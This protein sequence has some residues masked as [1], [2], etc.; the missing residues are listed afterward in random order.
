M[1]DY[2]T[3]REELRIAYPSHGHALWDPDPWRPN[4]PVQLG[5]VGYIREG[6]FYCLFNA[7]HPARLNVTVPDLITSPLMTPISRGVERQMYFYSRHVA[8]AS[9]GRRDEY[10]SSG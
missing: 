6:K 8:K 3:F 7:F 5:D 10:Y 1:Q 9:R 2:Q 4:I